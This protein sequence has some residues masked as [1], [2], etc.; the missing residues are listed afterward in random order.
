MQ[1]AAMPAR[2]AL[3]M[4]TRQAAASTHLVHLATTQAKI[5]HGDDQAL[6]Q[7]LV[8]VGALQ[9]PGDAVPD[10]R[11]EAQADALHVQVHVQARD[12]IDQDLRLQAAVKKGAEG[13]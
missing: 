8:D 11:R 6:D 10:R 12:G 4:R 13:A 2:T 1:A 9:C 3:S 7:V 5:S